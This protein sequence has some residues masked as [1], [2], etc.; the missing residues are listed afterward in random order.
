MGSSVAD[1]HKALQKVFTIFGVRAQ[2]EVSSAADGGHN[3]TADTLQSLRLPVSVQP[4]LS[5]CVA[6]AHQT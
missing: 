6:D 5:L 2:F 4:P 3:G 1:M